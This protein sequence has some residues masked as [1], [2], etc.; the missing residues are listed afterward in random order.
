VP[1]LSS[2]T[3]STPTTTTFSSKHTGSYAEFQ[4]EVFSEKNKFLVLGGVL[5]LINKFSLSHN[6]SF[7]CYLKYLPIDVLM[8]H[9]SGEE[10]VGTAYLDPS[11]SELL[12]EQEETSICRKVRR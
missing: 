4:A 5:H 10:K 3:T 7:S 12:A 2:Q 1:K 9:Y 8:D 6:F 11:D